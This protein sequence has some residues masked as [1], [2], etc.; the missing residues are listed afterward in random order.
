M[1]HWS[2]L[3]GTRMRTELFRILGR[4]VCKWWP[5]M[6]EIFLNSARSASPKT[7]YIGTALTGFLLIKSVITLQGNPQHFKRK[8]TLLFQST[9]SSKTVKGRCVSLLVNTLVYCILSYGYFRHCIIVLYTQYTKCNTVQEV[10]SNNIVS[11]E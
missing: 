7:S 6:L 1:I 11:H 3:L 8:K 5:G 4:K 10:I 9:V 2:Q